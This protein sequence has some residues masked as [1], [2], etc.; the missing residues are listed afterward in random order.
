M[1]KSGGT[2]TF[3]GNTIPT[4]DL[5]ALTLHVKIYFLPFPHLFKIP[6]VTPIMICQ[7]ELW[8]FPQNPEQL[9][10][11]SE[12]PLYGKWN[13]FAGLSPKTFDIPYLANGMFCGIFPKN[14][15]LRIFNC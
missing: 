15:R 14:I 6:F 11:H 3:G 7:R 1:V 8:N 13:V 5:G 12:H 10:V 2:Y 9:N 4:E